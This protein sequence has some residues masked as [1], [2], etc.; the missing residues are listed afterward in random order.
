[1]AQLHQALTAVCIVYNADPEPI[2]R[3]CKFEE[4]KK[5]ATTD[6]KATDEKYVHY[7]AR[8]STLDLQLIL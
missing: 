2:V 6:G 8:E 7:H 5:V 4:L 3:A 1:M